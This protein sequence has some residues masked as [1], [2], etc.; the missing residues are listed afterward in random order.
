MAA[1]HPHPGPQQRRVKVIGGRPDPAD[2]AGSLPR[3]DHGWQIFMPNDA[4]RAR[5]VPG[6]LGQPAPSLW[7]GDDSNPHANRLSARPRTVPPPAARP[8]TLRTGALLPHDHEALSCTAQY[9][10]SR[11]RNLVPRAILPRR[12]LLPG[13]ECPGG[14]V[15]SP[16]T[17][18]TPA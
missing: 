13:P 8:A 2:V 11:S 9:R 14:P 12:F 1:F 4:P 16:V 17:G 7:P 15:I 18:S 5:L 10:T 6:R 3:R